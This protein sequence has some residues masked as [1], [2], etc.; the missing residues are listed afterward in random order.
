LHGMTVSA[1]E[2]C[3]RL[4][5]PE[6][7]VDVVMSSKSAQA[8]VVRRAVEQCQN[9]RLYFDLPSLAPLIALADLAVGA[10]GA[11]VWERLCLGLPSVIVTVAENQKGLGAALQSSGL[12]RLA[13]HF[14]VLGPDGLFLVLHAAANDRDLEGWS[15]RCLKTCD[16]QGTGRVVDALIGS[17]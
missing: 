16:G 12:A 15:M 8:G 7:A 2:A 17:P 11:T 10:S 4:Q 1:V 5:R 9:S 6:I 13:G 3:A 14:D